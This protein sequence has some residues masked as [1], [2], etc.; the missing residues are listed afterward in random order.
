MRNIF[1]T[2][3]LFSTTLLS[4]QVR[5]VSETPSNNLLHN[6]AIGLLTEWMDAFLNYQCDHPDPALNGGILCPACARMHGRIGDAVLPLMYLADKTGN[7]KYLNGAKQLMAWMENVHRPDGS[8][9]KRRARL[10]LERYDG[11]CLHS[12]LRSVTTSWPLVRRLHPKPLE[13]TIV[14]SRRVHDEEPV[15]LQPQTRRYA[16]HERELFRFG[17]L[18]PLC[19]RRMVRPSRLQARSPRDSCRTEE[20]LHKKRRLPVW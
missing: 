15:H 9:M 18:R 17:D 3:L 6:E 13:A 7:P 1:F 5:N 8:W 4:G 10:G 2:V 20:L 16:E 14:A 11:L 12:S 19:H